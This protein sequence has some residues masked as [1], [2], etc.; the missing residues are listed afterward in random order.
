MVDSYISPSNRARASRLNG[1]VGKV[2]WNQ[3]LRKQ[4]CSSKSPYLEKFDF[5]SSSETARTLISWCGSSA[6]A[7][8]LPGLGGGKPSKES[9]THTLRSFTPRSEERRVGKEC[10]SRW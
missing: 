3:P 6:S 4:T 7:G 1:A 2:S 8:Y 10:R 5:T 9:A